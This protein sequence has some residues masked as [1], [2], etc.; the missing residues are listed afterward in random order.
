MNDNYEDHYDLLTAIQRY[1]QSNPK[2]AKTI[3]VTVNVLRFPIVLPFII[4]YQLGQLSEIA[5]EYIDDAIRVSK[6]CY[7]KARCDYDSNATL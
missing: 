1:K 3:E 2:E 7:F 5:A 6:R 4:L